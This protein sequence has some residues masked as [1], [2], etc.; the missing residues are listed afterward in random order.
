VDPDTDIGGL[1]SSAERAG[2][3][4]TRGKEPSRAESEGRQVKYII[5]ASYR[6][7]NRGYELDI[8][9]SAGGNDQVPTYRALLYQTTF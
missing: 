4:E 8:E 7:V 1:V 2:A 5:T 9:E 3:R 6:P